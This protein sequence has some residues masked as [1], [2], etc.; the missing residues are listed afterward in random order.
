MRRGD[1]R[2]ESMRLSQVGPCRTHAFRVAIRSLLVALLAATL[3]IGGSTLAMARPARAASSGGLF[4]AQSVG[5]GCLAMPSD[6]VSLPGAVTGG[7]ELVLLVSGQGYKGAAP[8]V[9][10]VSDPVNGSWTALANDHS[11]TGDGAKYLSYAVYVVRKAKA[12]SGV[13]ATVEQSV[14]QSAASATLLDVR[15]SSGIAYSSF[16]SN[17]TH[18]WGPGIGNTSVA[19]SAGALVL[20][21]FGV[22]NYGESTGVGSGWTMQ[23]AVG[24][25]TGVVS[26]VQMPSKSS[27]VPAAGTIGSETWYIGGELSLVPGG[28]APVPV[29]VNTVAPSVSGAAQQGQTLTASRGSWSNSPTSYGYQWQS[30]TSTCSN[31]TGQTASAYTASSGDVGK[32]LQVIVSATNGGGSASATSNQTQTITAAPA[33][34]G[35][36]GLNGLHVRGN[37]MVDGSGNIVHLH[38]ANRSGTEY[39]CIQGWG[40]FDGPN[41]APSVAA[42]AAWHINIVR[43]PLNEDCWL[44]INGVNPA[45]SGAN[46]INAVVNYVNLLHS[47]GIYAELSLMFG[48]PGTAQAT[49]QNGAPDQDHSPAMWA[50]MAQTFKNDPNVILAP[51]SE[52]WYWP[53]NSDWQCWLNGCNNLANYGGGPFDGD[54]TCGNNCYYYTTA[55]TQEAVTVMRQNAYHGPIAITCLDYANGCGAYNSNGMTGSWVQYKPT[56]PDNSVM[57]EV[58]LYGGNGC[59]TASCLNQEILPIRQAGYPVMLGEVG[60]YYNWSDCPSTSYMQ[61]FIPWAEANDVGMEAWAWDTWGACSGGLV[62]NYNGTAAQGDGAYVQSNYTSTYPA[63]P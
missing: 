15:G 43:V 10:G 53:Q 9:K 49:F 8:V 11:L 48:A 52:T 13:T 58:H 50:S 27:M 18:S 29:P 19:G 40:M 38:G 28:S 20:E 60:E 5:K 6:H 7:D 23:S 32:T 36:S 59:A 14:G 47:Y 41:D 3:A 39:A 31:I 24:V 51:W 46:Y 56:D 16:A 2:I 44:G 61:Q 33:G 42:M 4:L 30:C 34:G 45:Y 62:S 35:G 57:A 26:G 37:E 54:S 55:G 21:L 12:S 22:Y 17:I 63:N 1:L 25:C